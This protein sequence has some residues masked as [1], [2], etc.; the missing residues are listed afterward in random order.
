[1]TELSGQMKSSI[2]ILGGFSSTFRN[3]DGNGSNTEIVRNDTEI[4]KG[5]FHLGFNYNQLLTKK[6]YL[7][8]GIRYLSLGYQTKPRTLT[9]ADMTTSDIYFTYDYLFI[10]VPI[11]LRYEFLDQKT[12]V[13]FIELGF[14]PMYFFSNKQ[15]TFQDGEDRVSMR[16]PITTDFNKLIFA[17][18]ANIG[19]NYFLSDG[20]CLYL[21]GLLRYN[22]TNL[23]TDVD[24]KELLYG[25]GVEL[26]VRRALSFKN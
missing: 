21:Q 9:F 22:L 20:T 18:N 4:K 10:E 8:T 2:D 15:V 11:N 3:I 14:S 17:F 19:V 25:I 16:R 1:M 7:K 24:F 5:N 12:M 13:P 23:V 6:L 26:G